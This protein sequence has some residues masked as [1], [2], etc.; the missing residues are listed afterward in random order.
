M[1]GGFRAAARRRQR[2]CAQARRQPC[3]PPDC[4]RRG[5][6]PLDPPPA[7][8]E[9]EGTA[10]P[11]SLAEGGGSG[12]RVGFALLRGAGS[13]AV[14]S[15]GASL[16]GRQVSIGE[17]PS[18][19]IPL[20]Q[21]GRG[22]A[23]PP[24]SLS[25]GG[26]CGREA[27]LGASRLVRPHAR[28]HLRSARALAHR[29]RSPAMLKPLLSQSMTGAD[30]AHSKCSLRPRQVRQQSTTGTMAICAGARQVRLGVIEAQGTA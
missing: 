30:L 26:G 7:A 29:G 25:E 18:P 15:L 17:A 27:P 13:G 6:L 3:G 4:H 1:E 23:G 28:S 24:S 11:S 16:A 14:P 22:K 2:R 10:P 21:G 12:W 9:G 8:R 20:P 5:T 19:L